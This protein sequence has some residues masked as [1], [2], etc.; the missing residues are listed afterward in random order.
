MTPMSQ[1]PAF[2]SAGKFLPGISARVVKE[3]G[4]DALQRESGELWVTGP[5]MASEYLNDPTS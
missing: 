4:T 5:A 1:A 2:G 3:D